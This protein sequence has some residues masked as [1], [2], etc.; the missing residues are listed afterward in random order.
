MATSRQVLVSDVE[1]SVWIK[2][3]AP[4]LCQAFLFFFFLRQFITK[5][6][7]NTEFDVKQLDQNSQSSSQS[8]LNYYLCQRLGARD[9]ENEKY[10]EFGPCMQSFACRAAFLFFVCLFPIKFQKS[11]KINFVINLVC[12]LWGRE[13]AGLSFETSIDN[14]LG[15]I[16]SLVLVLMP[17]LNVQLKIEQQTKH[18]LL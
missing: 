2:I 15:I 17:F 8:I 7:S 6:K 4:I 18:R 1:A 14:A 9:D 10:P 16:V 13:R 12:M 5:C 11:L 3:Q